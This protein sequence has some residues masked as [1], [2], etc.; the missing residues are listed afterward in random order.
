MPVSTDFLLFALAFVL[1]A[2]IHSLTASLGFK[3][4]SRSLVG[5]RLHQAFFRL[6]YN[7]FSLLTFVPVLLLAAVLLPD[8]VVWSF[9]PPL[10]WLFRAIQLLGAVGLL[11]SVWQTGLWRF[12]GLRQAATYFRGGGAER[13]VC[14]SAKISANVWASLRRAWTIRWV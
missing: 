11:V 1:W 14:T 9:E 7:L 4:L 10:S 6:F 5:P 3:A 12:V 13:P 8:A 2:A